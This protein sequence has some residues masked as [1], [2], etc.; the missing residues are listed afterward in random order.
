[1][2]LIELPDDQALVNDLVIMLATLNVPRL[3]AERKRRDVSRTMNVPASQLLDRAQTIAAYVAARE[4]AKLKTP[5]PTSASP[6][7]SLSLLAG[8]G[9]AAATRGAR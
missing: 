7:L 4:V 1:M 3:K 2:R 6:R 9:L 8:P 5:V